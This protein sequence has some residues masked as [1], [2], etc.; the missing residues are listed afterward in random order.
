MEVPEDE[1]TETA[2][3]MKEDE[4]THD[5]EDMTDWYQDI[6]QILFADCRVLNFGQFLPGGKL[7]GA[8]LMVQNLT[9]C[10]QII[11]LAVDG[12]T[13]RYSRDE[14]V[15]EFPISKSGKVTAGDGASDL[16]FDLNAIEKSA[17]SSSKQV[18]IKN[19]EVLH[20]SR[21]IVNPIS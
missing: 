15:S 19:S 6:D 7:L 16:P 21:F 14:L 2:Q 11:E 10:E 18:F 4:Y 5:V 8:N 13:F 1:D 12:Q 9:A 20:E 17:G 3:E